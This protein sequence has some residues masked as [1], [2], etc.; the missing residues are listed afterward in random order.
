MDALAL[1]CN[2]YGDGPATLRQLRAAGVGALEQVVAVPEA[3]LARLLELPRATAARFQR[4]AATLRERV[5]PDADAAPSNDGSQP[6][7]GAPGHRHDLIARVLDTWRACDAREERAAAAEAHAQ[8]ETSHPPA[9]VLE[10][11][12]VDGLDRVL[13]RALAEHGVTTLE[14]LADADVDALARHTGLPITRL[15]HVRFLARRREREQTLQPRSPLP[16]PTVV[17]PMPG[18]GSAAALAPL[19]APGTAALDPRDWFKSGF[20]SDRPRFSPSEIP[21]LAA[22][23]RLAQDLERAAVLRPALAGS[24]RAAPAT[25]TIAGPFA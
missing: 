11:F 7:D 2:L 1:L 4:E 25:A 14:A 22:E 13:C 12:A 15:M 18:P 21:F 16:R 5:T 24:E 8:P 9:S 6:S 10:P 17:Q 20:A 3:D 19:H 23:G